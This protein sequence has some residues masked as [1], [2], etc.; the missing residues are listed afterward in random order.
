MAAEHIMIQW[1]TQL[2]SGS[3]ECSA[4]IARQG[5]D[6]LQT[7]S[8]ISLLDIKTLYKTARRPGGAITVGT[9]ENQRTV[10]H[11]GHSIPGLLQANL[12]LSVHAAKYYACVV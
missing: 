7:L 11:P 3:D 4:A 10:P 12:E 1:L 9:G 2:G 6:T 8:E 5:L